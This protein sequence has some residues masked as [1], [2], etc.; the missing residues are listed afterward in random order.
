MT[1]ENFRDVLGDYQDAVVARQHLLAMVE[2]DRHS[3]QSN[4]GLGMLLHNELAQDDRLVAR[5]GPESK[6][7]RKAARRLG[8]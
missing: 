4:L 5:V 1:F 6:S 2:E 3:A 8:K 7:V